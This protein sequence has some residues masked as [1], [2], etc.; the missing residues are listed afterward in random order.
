[1]TKYVV[2]V[3]VLTIVCGLAALYPGTAPVWAEDA[4]ETKPLDLAPVGP[5][6][7]QQ[8]LNI[9]VN[10]LRSAEFKGTLQDIANMTQNVNV[11]TATLQ[12]AVNE[13]AELKKPKPAEAVAEG[14][15]K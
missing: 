13:L 11:A 12:N 14:E 3:A 10:A 9:V 1:M 4:K 5:S 7:E 2:V 6:Q 8:A 15:K